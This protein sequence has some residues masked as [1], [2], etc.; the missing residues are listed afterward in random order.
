MR[1]SLHTAIIC[2]PTPHI[3]FFILSYLINNKYMCFTELQLLFNKKS[4]KMFC[5]YLKHTPVC[6]MVAIVDILAL[7]LDRAKL[8]QSPLLMSLILKSHSF[9][10]T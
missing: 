5:K 7:L 6:V 10:W 8:L 1:T 9:K 3:S 2:I 4:S